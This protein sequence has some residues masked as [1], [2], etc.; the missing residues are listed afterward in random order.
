M[1]EEKIYIT[2][3]LIKTKVFKKGEP[4]SM[5]NKDDSEEMLKVS[6]K[7]EELVQQL[8]LYMD[9]N[10]WVNLDISRRRTP[11]EKGI[12]HSVALNTFKPRSSR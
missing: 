10:G 4:C 6:I 1:P 12:T 9:T 11:S 3:I 5:C 2:G 8:E 7:V